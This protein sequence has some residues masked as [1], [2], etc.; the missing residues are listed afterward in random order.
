MLF[1]V[2]YYLRSLYRVYVFVGICLF[3]CIFC[4]H[5]IL[6]ENFYPRGYVY[7]TL[8]YMLL[9]FEYPI[10]PAKYAP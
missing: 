6:Y 7:D 5:A 3:L 8:L 4:S 10:L 1:Q 9:L 2:R